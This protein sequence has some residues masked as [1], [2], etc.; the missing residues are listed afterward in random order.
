MEQPALQQ[1]IDV[2]TR[3][4]ATGKVEIAGKFENLKRGAILK[5]VY[6]ICRAE[7]IVDKFESYFS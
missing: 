5:T 6:S 3:N 1:E 4:F 7:A 2:E